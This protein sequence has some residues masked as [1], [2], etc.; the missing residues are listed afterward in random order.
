MLKFTLVMCLTFQALC[1]PVKTIWKNIQQQPSLSAFV[2]KL[3][4]T[5]LQHVSQLLNSPGALTLFAP[6]NNALMDSPTITTDLLNYHLISSVM[7][8]SDLL[9]V[10]FVDTA[11]INSSVSLL[12]PNTA[13]RV[14]IA[15]DGANLTVLG[16]IESVNAW[17]AQAGGVEVVC[18]NGIFNIIDSLFQYP[19]TTVSGVLTSEYYTNMFSA[20]NR[21]LQREALVPSLDSLPGI[22]LIAPTNQAFSQWKTVSLFSEE[23]IREVLQ[24]H[25]LTE[26]VFFSTDLLKM[27]GRQLI[28]LDGPTV[29]VVVEP[30]TPTTEGSIMIGNAKIV[31]TDLQTIN[32]IV[33]G[34]SRIILPPPPINSSISKILRYIPTAELLTNL[35]QVNPSYVPVKDLL[36]KAIPKTLLAP[37]DTAVS[38]AEKAGNFNLSDVAATTAVLTYHV[39]DGEVTSAD[40]GSVRVVPT[41]YSSPLLTNQTQVVVFDTVD[42]KHTINGIEIVTVEYLAL[43]GAVHTLSTLLSLPDDLNTTLSTLGLTTLIDAL[44]TTNDTHP[45]FE[46]A[47]ITI[48]APTNQAFISCELTDTVPIEALKRHVFAGVYYTSSLSDGEEITSIGGDRYTVTTDAHGHLLT[49]GGIKVVQTNILTAS[50]VVHVIEQVL[51]CG[52]VDSDKV[53]WWQVVLII[54][55]VVV[56]VAISYHF[57]C[58]KKQEPFGESLFDQED[59]SGFNKYGATSKESAY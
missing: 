27:D 3:N 22:T 15:W 58:K 36:A 54:G 7:P 57:F 10:N 12:P 28:T 30:P 45:L 43:E 1:D 6:S 47:D 48:F 5:E 29:K 18:S 59:Y 31:V 41:H 20:L 24:Y 37:D 2:S 14:E 53:K 4:T 42:G 23:E 40:L 33:H 50:G 44:S 11:L 8:R 52:S 19:N 39:L 56:I 21:Q 26:G 51:G 34:C 49:V 32:G 17:V 55:A 16:G 9:P 38:V 25:V 35:I 46:S 13:V